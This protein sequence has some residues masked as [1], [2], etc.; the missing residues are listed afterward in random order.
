MSARPTTGPSAVL[1][2]WAWRLGGVGWEG[3]GPSGSVVKARAYSGG[4]VA[5]AA[6]VV[7]DGLYWRWLCVRGNIQGTD[8]YGLQVDVL[9][10]ENPAAFV[11]QVGVWTQP[12]ETRS[13]NGVWH[14][15]MMRAPGAARPKVTILF[16]GSDTLADTFGPGHQRALADEG[17]RRVLELRTRPVIAG[18]SRMS[19]AP[20]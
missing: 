1:A 9:E 17:G 2:A 5:E 19:P 18:N 10:D 6:K 13:L 8:V 15:L 20:S 7:F 14:R 4:A 12:A 16:L 11:D 3:D